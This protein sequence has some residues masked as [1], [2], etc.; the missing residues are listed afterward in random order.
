MRS[1]ADLQNY[2]FQGE[3]SIHI[4]CWWKSRSFLQSSCLV[5]ASGNYQK[6]V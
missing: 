3:G 1:F 4:F 2:Q 6:V 5:S